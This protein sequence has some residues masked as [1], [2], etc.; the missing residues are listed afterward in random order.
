MVYANTDSD[1]KI[2]VQFTKLLIWNL[3]ILYHDFASLPH[4]DILFIKNNSRLKPKQNCLAIS[5][6]DVNDQVDLIVNINKH[7][8]F[9]NSQMSNY[10]E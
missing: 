4:D 9:Y 6:G 3:Q 7:W 10:L 8:S 1:K 5:T 2:L